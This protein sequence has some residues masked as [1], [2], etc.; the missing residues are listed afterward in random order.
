MLAGVAFAKPSHAQQGSTPPPVDPAAVLATLK[1]LRTRQP[2]LVNRQTSGV[3]S[4][5]AAALADPGKAYQEATIAVQF[6]SGAAGDGSRIAEWRKRQGDLLRN[7]DFINGLRLQLMYL[8]FTWQHQMGAKPAA[9]L[10]PLLDYVAQVVAA[11]DA[12]SAFEALN[13]PIGDT[14]FANYFQVTPFLAGMTRWADHP[15]DVEAIYEKTILPEMR[16]EKDPRVLAYW[17]SHIQSE[18]ERAN[19]SR[20]PLILNKFTTI[21]LPEL[22]WE[23]AEDELVI[24]RKDQA[25]N[26]MLALVKAHPA[27]PDFQ[28]WASELEEIVAPQVSP[29][30]APSATP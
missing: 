8:A 28:K 7:R 9:Q 10:A 14:V 4:S 30:P 27:H 16:L 25:I 17:D 12:L 5:I 21:R 13:K 15:F 29:S 6:Q 19:A 1:D 2:A 26:D 20:N 22:L 23:R 18:S 3:L 11:G 24:G